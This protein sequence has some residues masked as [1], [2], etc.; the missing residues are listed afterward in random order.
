MRLTFRPL[1][2]A[3]KD[4]SVGRSTSEFY[5]HQ[6][7]LFFNN[8]IQ[9]S[10]VSPLWFSLCLCNLEE[11]IEGVSCHLSISFYVFFFLF[12]F[13]LFL[14]SFFVAYENLWFNVATHSPCLFAGHSEDCS[15]SYHQLLPS[16]ILFP[17]LYYLVLLCPLSSSLW[18]VISLVIVIH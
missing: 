10:S 5:G 1:H 2:V 6:P 8:L 13:T 12:Y 17:V 7:T 9:F 15:L 11:K 18:T 3:K 16:G 4:T 14:G